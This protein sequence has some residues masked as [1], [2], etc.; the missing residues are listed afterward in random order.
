MTSYTR[1]IIK[2]LIAAVII[3]TSSVW[4]KTADLAPSVSG[5]YRM[6]IG[7]IFLVLI[8]K[9]N[10]YKLWQN[11]KYLFKLFLAA[12]FFAFDLYFWHRSIFFVGPGL[13][14]VLGNFQVFFMALA[15]YLFFK[16]KIGMAFIIGLLVTIAGLFILVGINWSELT[17]EYRTGVVYG[18][19]TA[20]SYTG[21]MLSLR[22]VQS[23]R[24]T[25]NAF[26][27]LGVMSLLCALLM[28]IHLVFVGQDIVVGSL[29]SW[30]SILIL[31][32]VCQV[33]GWVLITQ[34]M[35]NLPTSIVGVVLLLQPALSM[36][37]DIVFFDRP[38]GLVD[39]IGLSMVLMGVYL[40]TL[41]K[42]KKIKV[43]GAQY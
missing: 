31:G 10:Q 17:S 6:F 11:W 21:F 28:Y 5:F 15:G 32:I 16:E 14:T 34:S 39:F 41:K 7:G 37:W 33:I 3:S 22:H 20:L 25:L 2:I 29:E 27:N 42:S 23:S 36:L 19:L 43:K 24:N 18:L 13:A 8:C 30:I 12:A 40:A 1:N 38:M 4:V 35:P 26:A 9:L